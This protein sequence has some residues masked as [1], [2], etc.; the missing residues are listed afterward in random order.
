MPCFWIG[1]V[2]TRV[3]AADTFRLFA[4]GGIAHSPLL[5]GR[6]VTLEERAVKS[7]VSLDRDATKETRRI[8]GKAET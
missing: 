4:A 1:T 3:V 5:D 7:E 8:N 2:E 6:D